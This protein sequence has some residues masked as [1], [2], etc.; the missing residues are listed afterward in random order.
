MG[1]IFSIIAAIAA[2]MVLLAGAS[3]YW[4]SESEVGN[5]KKMATAAAANGL[6]VAIALQ[7]DTLQRSVDGLADSPDVIAALSSGDPAIIA[8]MSGKVQGLVPGALRIRLLLPNVNEPDTTLT[9]HMGFGDVDMA[10]STLSAKQKP[11]IQGEGE[12]RHLAFTS[13]VIHNGKVVGVV[14]AS[15]KADLVNQMAA[16]TQLSGG[17]VE[18]KQD[19][20]VLATVGN[21]AVKT[22]E[23]ETITPSN[24]RWS[25]AFWPESASSLG[26]ISLIAAIVVIPA[27]LACLAFFMGYRKLVDYLQQDQSTLLK[28]AK[29]MMLG[30]NVGNY[31]VQLPEMQPIISALAQFKRVIEQDNKPS[32]NKDEIKDFDFFTDTFDLDFTEDSTASAPAPIPMMSGTPVSLTGELL[33]HKDRQFANIFRGYDIR[34]II[35][36]GLSE[37]AVGNIG[38]AVASE[39]KQLGI[40]TIVIGRDGRLS[41]PALATALAKGITL[42]GCDVMDIGLVPTP[43]L[44]FVAHHTEGRS[45][46]MITGS[47]NPPEYNGLKIVLNDET[48]SGNRIQAIKQRIEAGDYSQGETGSIEQNTL[49]VNE[50]IGIIS[51]DI[52]IVRP[53]K[54]VVDCGNGAAGQLGPVLLKTLGC[55]VIGLFCEID[56]NFPNHHPDPSR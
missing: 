41:S 46:I 34:G 23:P 45:G 18:I 14:L 48:L 42:A 37:E 51:E 35:G 32:H 56:G 1:R 38:R 9:P 25:I 24:S 17:F 52:H 11:V 10:R 21:E 39:A 54:V 5:S 6:S 40:K 43:V 30:K 29:D 22:D 4:F 3:T 44:Y 12:N 55:E 26:D 15:L 16:R 20:V 7:L 19:H 13:V 49:F 2:L 53:M 50:Y 27:L 31:P 47:H 8:S 33:Q 36:Q 28:A